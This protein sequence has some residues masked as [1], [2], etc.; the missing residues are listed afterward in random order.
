MTRPQLNPDNVD[1][2]ASALE[3]TYWY[4]SSWA[5]TGIV[6]EGTCNDARYIALE[7]EL[8]ERVGEPDVHLGGPFDTLGEA[9]AKAGEVYANVN[10]C[11]TCE[12]V[13]AGLNAFERS[14]AFEKEFEKQKEEWR[15]EREEH[16]KEMV[17]DAM[18]EGPALTNLEVE[19]LED[20]SIIEIGWSGAEHVK[21]YPVMWHPARLRINN[22]KELAKASHLETWPLTGG[23]QPYRLE[24]VSTPDGE[25]YGKDSDGNLYSLGLIGEYPFTIVKLVE[26]RRPMPRNRLAR[27][28]KASGPVALLVILASIYMLVG[29]G[30]CSNF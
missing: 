11:A 13:V 23:Y 7:L 25:P 6:H 2:Q 21:T 8:R 16:V 20:G 29:S 22:L 17:G 18:I 26:A 3:G 9:R 5:D 28:L 1:T 12:P 24:K 10:V 30:M 4:R 19:A 15:Q 27:V 14:V